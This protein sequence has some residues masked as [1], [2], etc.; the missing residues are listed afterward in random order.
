MQN[1]F[2]VDNIS[3]KNFM[4]NLSKE[5]AVGISCIGNEG[6]RHHIFT[7]SGKLISRVEY[8]YEEDSMPVKE[9]ATPVSTRVSKCSPYSR[10]FFL[11][12]L[13]S[14]IGDKFSQFRRNM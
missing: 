6:R 1:N 14:V 11:Q 10:K 8:S 9:F 12:L 13:N 3:A 5:A 7:S 2:C 4:Q